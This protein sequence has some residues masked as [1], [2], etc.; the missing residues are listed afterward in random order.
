M[1]T[2]KIGDYVK[3]MSPETSLNLGIMKVQQIDYTSK[4]CIC[5]CRGG[6][7]LTFY[8]KLYE[9]NPNLIVRYEIH[10]DC[11]ELD[12]SIIGNPIDVSYTF[13]QSIHMP[14]GELVKTLLERVYR[15]NAVNYRNL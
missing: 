1:K 11:L 13:G 15:N 6:Y 14:E 10:L 7:W 8:K 2:I 9:I 12:P 4:K 5:Y 3:F